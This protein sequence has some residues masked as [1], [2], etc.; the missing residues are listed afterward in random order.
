MMERLTGKRVWDEAKQDLMHEPGYKY[1]WER[2]NEI[3]NM[4]GDEYDLDLIRELV[5]KNKITNPP[6]MYNKLPQKGQTVWYWDSYRISKGIVQFVDE[7]LGEFE[8]D[9]PDEND[10]DI[11]VCSAWGDSIVNSKESALEK[12]KARIK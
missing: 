12:M 4:F 2:L 5:K 1:V 9:F 7:V 10:F 8:V 11:F 3:E 6:D